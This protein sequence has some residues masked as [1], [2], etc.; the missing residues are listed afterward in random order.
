MV[1]K[2]DSAPTFTL[3]GVVDDTVET[4]SLA[5]AT[6]QDR[7]VLLLFY[8]FDFSPVCTN[9][10][11]AIRDAEW[12]EFTP[13]LDV[14]AASGDSTYSHQAFGAEYGLN[15]PLLSDSDGSVAAAYD[16]C[17]DEW[18]NHES[19]PQRAVFLIDSTQTVRYAWSTDDALEK[20]DFFPVKEALDRLATEQDAVDDTDI[21]L[22]IEYEESLG[23][24]S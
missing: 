24:T 13:Q 6:D 3:P 17:Y 22:A 1:T 9:E 20:P 14:W 10:L 23:Q 21:E 4:F 5:D 8:P 7:A 11:C 18:E 15:F 19:V 2:G 16:V 12:F